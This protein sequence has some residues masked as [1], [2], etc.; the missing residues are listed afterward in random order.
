MLHVCFFNQ[1]LEEEDGKEGKKRI[2]MINNKK[3]GE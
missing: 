1:W 3:R 2:M